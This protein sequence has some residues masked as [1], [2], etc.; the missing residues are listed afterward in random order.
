MLRIQKM[1]KMEE[2]SVIVGLELTRILYGG[3]GEEARVR[4]LTCYDANT[5]QEEVFK[6]ERLVRQKRAKICPGTPRRLAFL[7]QYGEKN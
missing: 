7:W 4:E 2:G 3:I 1:R 6:G 5:H